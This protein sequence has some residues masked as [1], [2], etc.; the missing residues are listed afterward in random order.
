MARAALAFQVRH[1]H[2]SR[3]AKAMAST[4]TITPVTINT[5][6][7]SP[8]TTVTRLHDQSWGPVR[9]PSPGGEPVPGPGGGVI[10][11][12]PDRVPFTSGSHS[13]V[14]A[15]ENCRSRPPARTC[16]IRPPELTSA[17]MLMAS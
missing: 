1:R 8:A 12:A 7:S 17:T 9:A 10:A 11:L 16:Q 13:Q 2:A 5:R 14:A 15:F 3:A 4:P 6:L